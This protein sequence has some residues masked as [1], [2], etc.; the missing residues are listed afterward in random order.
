MPTARNTGK[1]LG[2]KELREMQTNLFE[3]KINLTTDTTEKRGFTSGG[4]EPACENA[5]PPWKCSSLTSLTRHEGTF[6]E[7]GTLKFKILFSKR[8]HQ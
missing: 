6:G 3:E 5:K 7:S 4:S 1:R 2:G 8:Y